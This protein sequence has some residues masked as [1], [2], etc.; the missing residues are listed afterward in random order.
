MSY[1][2]Q[3]WSVRPVVLPAALPDR[4]KWHPEGEVWQ[5]TA[6]SWQITV[7]PSLKVS[8]EDIPE[9]VVGLLPG[10]CYLTETNP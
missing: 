6:K 5:H 1:D 3:I 8:L 2:I 7:T 10:I 4:Q 9:D